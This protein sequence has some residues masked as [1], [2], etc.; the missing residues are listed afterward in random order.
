MGDVNAARSACM[1]VICWSS[2]T[3][4]SPSVI[5]RLP[6]EPKK[7]GKYATI[8][9]CHPPCSE[10]QPHYTSHCTP[11]RNGSPSS[12]P[13][14]LTQ[15]HCTYSERTTHHMLIHTLLFGLWCW[16]EGTNTVHRSGWP[17]QP[18]DSVTKQP[19]GAHPTLHPCQYLCPQVHDGCHYSHRHA[20]C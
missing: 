15:Q 3:L 10:H 2:F 18:V 20:S 14:P 17:G 12:H 9:V 1:V 19:R 7:R 4:S 8:H 16:Q 11:H 6:A 13:H 5:P